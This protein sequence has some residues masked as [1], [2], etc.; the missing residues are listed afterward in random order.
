MPNW[1]DIDRRHA[2][3][4][5]LLIAA[6]TAAC[7]IVFFIDAI[8]RASVEGPEITVSTERAP[9]ITP[10]TAVWVAGRPVGR[11]LSVRFL[12]PADGA[13]RIVI[14][15]VLERGV[16]EVLRADA[17][18][19]LHPGGLLEPVVVAIDPGTGSLPRWDLARPIPSGVTTMTPERLREMGKTLADVGV[20]LADE[21]G[22][23]RRRIDTGGGTL[24]RL[25]ER[26][27]V[28]ADATASLARLDTLVRSGDVG[29]TFGR[30]M[31]DTAMGSRLRRIRHRLAVLDTLN[32]RERATASY[33]EMARAVDDFQTRLARMSARLDAGEG[34][35]GRALHDGA[36]ARQMALL[37]ARMDSLTVELM[38]RPDRWLRVKIF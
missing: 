25:V 11:V 1:T 33:E 28:L 3:I 35:A 9:G 29:G 5:L 12:P 14:R 38:K 13:D 18:A 2:R 19:V 6:L 32:A 10:G 16:D 22:R 21:A 23:L 17:H 34:T 24:A 30:L 27:A 31:S 15:A 36:I 20:G 4:G 37:H 8:R 26:P 7:V